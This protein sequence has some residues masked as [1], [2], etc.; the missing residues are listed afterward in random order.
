M[1]KTQIIG[2]MA[3]DPNGL[4]GRTSAKHLP[5]SYPK[6]SAFWQALVKNQALIVGYSSFVK[7]P[8]HLLKDNLIV[9][10][11]TQQQSQEKN[12]WFFK[13]ID[14]FLNADIYQAH[15]A[16]Y[17]LGGAITMNQFL[18]KQLIDEFYLTEIKKSYF[19]DIFL[20]KKYLQ[21]WK[22]TCIYPCD[23]FDIMHYIKKVPD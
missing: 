16:F 22:K 5:W 18:E 15:A 8:K 12:H 11:S 21:D 10:F 3:C 6:D 2:V 9:V 14:E 13:S 19:G 20:E 17:H 4:I 23:D 7:L 1:M